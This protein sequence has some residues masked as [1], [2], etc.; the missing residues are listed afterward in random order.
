M[1]S[2]LRNV[3]TL[4]PKTKLST[5]LLPLIHQTLSKPFSQS[6]TIPTKQERV[7]D[8]GYD[9][10]MEVEKKIRKVVKFHSLILSQPQNTIPISLLDTLARRLGLGFK[11]HEPGAFLL[12][13][14]HVFEVYEHPVQRILYCRLTRKALDQIR[15]EQEAV[16]SQIPEAVT[17]LRKLVMMSNTGRI[18]L[19]HV[20]IARSEFGLPEDFEY[21]VILK[22][23]QFFRLIDGEETRDKYIEIVDREQSLSVCAIE[24]V[25]EIEYRTKGI[26]AEDVRFSFVVNFPPGFKI[27]K[28][29]RIAVWKWQRLPYWSPYEDISGYDLRSLEAQKRLEKRAVACIHELLSLTV[30]KKIT[31]ERIAHF[32]NVMCLP[33]RLKEFL[34]QHQGIFYISTRGNYGKLHT[35]FLREA[36]KRGELVEPNEVYLARRK[37]AELVLMSPRKAKVDAELVRYR[38]GFDD[39][40]DDDDDDSE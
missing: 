5:K 26:D 14:P 10:Y 6:T 11:Q 7:R 32:R 16:V 25:R 18:R 30:E 31:L 4:K 19:E 38:N 17:R 37:L 33:K 1:K 20:R 9:N 29:F 39:E 35:V 36:Y 27:G 8:H 28:Y 13:F 21:S 34:L 22:H 24:R 12:K 15:D 40:D 3:S 2:L 23:P